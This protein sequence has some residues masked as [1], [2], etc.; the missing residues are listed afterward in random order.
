M[1]RLPS[2]TMS[3]FSQNTVFIR[4]VAC[5]FIYET[6]NLI[7]KQVGPWLSIWPGKTMTTLTHHKKSM[8][9]MALHPKEYVFIN[10]ICSFAS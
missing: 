2:F 10:I 5:A 4:I 1:P 6:M 7:K 3:I 9:A 8:R